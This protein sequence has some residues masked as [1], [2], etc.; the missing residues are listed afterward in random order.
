M[1]INLVVLAYRDLYFYKDYGPAVRDLQFLLSL[2]QI[3][4]V[5][6]TLLDRPVSLYERLLGKKFKSGVLD[7]HGIN[8]VDCTSFDLFGPFKR[9]L[10]LNK[11]IPSFLDK[12]LPK[13]KN[14][15][16]LN[17]FL[18]FMPIGAPKLKSLD[19]W[20]YW[21][22]FIDNFTKHNR[23]ESAERESVSVKYNFVKKHAQ[24]LTFVSNECKENII[25]TGNFSGK[26]EII[27][28]KLF[29]DSTKQNHSVNLRC[30]DEANFD[31]GF[32]G[33]VTNKIDIDFIIRLSRNFSVAIYGDFYDLKIKK[34]LSKLK[35]V[36]IHGGFHYDDL[37]SICLSFRVGLLPYLSNMSHDGSPLKLYEYL[38]YCRPV[39]TSID[40]EITD[41]KYIINYQSKDFAEKNLSHF[42]EL[43]GSG[44]IASLLDRDDY[45]S[46]H[47]LKI[48]E[49]L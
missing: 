23:F 22:D 34:K 37:P 44:Q 39:I 40:Y 2:S 4:N 38:R 46:T 31:F 18:D 35:N 26:T 12:V 9:R 49:E 25:S 21:Y 27:T 1:K 42:L 48:L 16:A 29:E 41:H 47:M 28:N 5:S 13:L 32:I 10:W 17:V 36:F 6:V 3:D 43:A 20:Y 15:D 19:G 8:V 14:D 30:G 7:E 45:L 11:S 24:L 33:F